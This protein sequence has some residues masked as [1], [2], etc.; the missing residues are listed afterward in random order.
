VSKDLFG[1]GEGTTP[2]TYEV[3]LGPGEPQKVYD[4]TRV[5]LEEDLMLFWKEGEEAA[6]L[7]AGALIRPVVEALHE[8][9][10]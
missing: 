5:T 8:V 9:V 3:C 10:E 6:C 2:R 7:Y 4:V 1:T